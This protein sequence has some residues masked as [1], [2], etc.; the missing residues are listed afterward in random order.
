MRN[1]PNR[2]PINKDGWPFP[3]R[4]ALWAIA[5]LGM[6]AMSGCSG[7]KKDTAVKPVTCPDGTV[8]TAEQVKA[9][10]GYGTAGFNATKA[11]PVKPHVELVGIPPSIQAFKE[12]PFR[13]DLSAGTYQ[14]QHSMLLSIRWYDRSIADQDLTNINK[15]PN[16][17]IKREHQ[18]LPISYNMTASFAKVQTVYIRAYMEQGGN[19]YWSKEVKLNVTQVMP[20][21]K[22]FPVKIGADGTPSPDVVMVVL[23]DAVQVDN[24][25]VP[26]IKCAYHTGPVA[27]ADFEAAMAVPS[28]TM[29]NTIVYQAPQVYEYACNDAGAHS[30]KVNVAV[31]A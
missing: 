3:M 23:G 2:K 28:D 22:V 6:L 29:S 24:S 1:A 27:T 26:G 25:Y 20:S 4:K 16:E 9:L 10:P 5:V 11:C 13:V 31:N 8:L 12:F 30:F 19:D 18:N 21:G 14:P 7:S 17:L 15:Y